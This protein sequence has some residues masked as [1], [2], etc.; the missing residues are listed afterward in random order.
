[1]VRKLQCLTRYISMTLST[2][3]TAKETKILIGIY[4]KHRQIFI[5]VCAVMPTQAG[6]ALRRGSVGICGSSYLSWLSRLAPLFSRPSPPKRTGHWT[7]PVHILSTLLCSPSE[8]KLYVN[9]MDRIHYEG[10]PMHCGPINCASREQDQ[11][12]NGLYSFD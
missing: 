1:M 4:L 6:P 9:T 5:Y 7:Q 3:C 11:S 12:A 8:K 10:D 2:K